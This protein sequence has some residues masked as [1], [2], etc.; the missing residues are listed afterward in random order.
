MQHAENRNKCTPAYTEP[1]GHEDQEKTMLQSWQ[2]FQQCCW[3]EFG[4]MSLGGDVGTKHNINSSKVRSCNDIP[5]SEG[6]TIQDASTSVCMN[7]PPTIIIASFTCYGTSIG[8]IR[9]TGFGLG[10][11]EVQ[12]RDTMEVLRKTRCLLRVGVGRV[13]AVIKRTLTCRQKIFQN[14]RNLGDAYDGHNQKRQGSPVPRFHFKVFKE[15]TSNQV[16]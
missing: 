4:G 15:D 10:Q 11:P 12:T 5:P 7:G 1:Q 13:I 16:V 3:S 14:S 9:K 6:F 2:S 8:K